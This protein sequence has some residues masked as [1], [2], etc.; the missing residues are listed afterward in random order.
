VRKWIIGE[1][2]QGRPDYYKE[3][4]V[5]REKMGVRQTIKEKTENNMLKLYGH[6]VCM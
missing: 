2:L 6:V 1:E 4:I 5:I 3:E